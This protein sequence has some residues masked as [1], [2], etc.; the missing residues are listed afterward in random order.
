MPVTRLC[1]LIILGR[2]QLGWVIWAVERYLCRREAHEL[3]LCYLSNVHSYSNKALNSETVSTHFW[4]IIGVLEVHTLACPV[5]PLRICIYWNWS[6]PCSIGTE[7]SAYN[8]TSSYGPLFPNGFSSSLSFLTHLL[9]AE[10]LLVHLWDKVEAFGSLLQ[11]L[12]ESCIKLIV[13]MRGLQDSAVWAAFQ[14]EKSKRNVQV[15]DKSRQI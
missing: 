10:T 13:S 11:L 14:L 8:T 4:R 5:H 12:D 1:S 15:E 7:V 9:S 6:P 2:K 3:I